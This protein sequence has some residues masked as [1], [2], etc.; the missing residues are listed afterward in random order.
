ML[1][2]LHLEIITKHDL[3]GIWKDVIV[4]YLILNTAFLVKT[5]RKGAEV[6][7]AIQTQLW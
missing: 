7:V 4:L 6:F 2:I 3:A 5:H 1:H